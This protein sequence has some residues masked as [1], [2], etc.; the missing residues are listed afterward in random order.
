MP[1]LIGQSLGRY[2]ILEQLGEGGMA[3][4]YKAYDTRLETDVAVKIIRTENLAP[5]I[6]ERALKRF[7]REAKALAKLTHSNIVKVTDYGEYEGKPY[8]VMPFLP[9]GT[10]KHSLQGKQMPW[11]DAVHLLLPIGRGLSYAHKQGM[12]HRDIK[13]SNILITEAGDPLLTDF[14]IAKI[15]DEESTVDLTGTSATVG[16][17]EY[18]APEQVTSKTVD[19][20]ADIY[21]LGVVLYEMITGRK[22][23]QAD[24]PMAVLFKQ[25]SEPLPR[26]KQ[27][28]HDL[29]EAVEKVLIKALA[30]KP[31]DRYQNM[32]EFVNAMDQLGQRLQIAGTTMQPNRPITPAETSPTD[33]PPHGAQPSERRGF[34][35]K[36]W[37]WGV[38]GASAVLGLICLIGAVVLIF[39]FLPGGFGNSLAASPQTP[40]LTGS[41]A[42]PM[43][44]YTTI[45]SPNPTDTIVPS[46]SS[47]CPAQSTESGK[48][49]I[50]WF[51]G[52]GT[53]NDPGQL[54]AESSVVNDFNNSQD[55]IQLNLEEMDY[56]TAQTTLSAEFANESGPDIIGPVGWGVS[57]PFHGQWMDLSLLIKCNKYDTTQFNPALVNMYKT[58]EGQV[59]L[60]FAVYPSAFFYNTELFKIA[61]L[62]Y[63]PASYGAKYTMPDGS[64]VD[65]TW[66]TV[67]QVAKWLT[68]DSA[69]RNATEA[70]FNKARIV[71]YGFTWQYENHPSFWGTFWGNGS[72]VAANGKIAQAPEAWVAAWKWTYNS[73][74]GSQP[75]A[76]NAAVEG[77]AD[78][79]NGNPFN[80]G[81][82]AMTDQPVWYTC[83]MGKITTWDAGIMPMYNGIVA[84]RIDADSLRIWK[85]TKHPQE[86]FTVLSYLIGKGVQKLII[87]TPDMPA[88]YGSVPAITA[89]LQTWIDAKKVQFP[90]VKNWETVL[91]GLNYPDIPSAEYYMPNFSD[92]WNRGNTFANLVRSQGGLDMD[93]E[94]ATYISDL[95]AIFNK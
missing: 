62:N 3:T 44:T 53:G 56:D 65:W 8:L 11:Q 48:V 95:T 2:Q 26:P 14:G 41:N 17:P 69:G 37:M 54:T 91:A 83:C 36:G 77:S 25:A 86:A 85:G 27:F 31:E 64:Q 33:V 76:A 84:G 7:E 47:S 88:A 1:N 32:D 21:A 15:L 74:W 45:L 80:S 49:Q 4:V 92:A 29:P 94:I 93:Q 10:L 75:W 70:G 63:P 89:D 9:G 35:V 82:I 60:P 90:W 39:H 78:F 16:T 38:V 46:S 6:V 42:S 55:K 22:P 79:E 23:F 43:P 72:M 52:L 81:K 67:A 28:V 50:R 24:T 18:M 12:V 59:A 61:G 19:A 20:R 66:D 13:P 30:K 40:V 57:N 73:I 68:I 71:Q 51:I 34:S 5:S 58:D 87:G